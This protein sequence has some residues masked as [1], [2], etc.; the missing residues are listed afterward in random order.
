[1]QKDTAKL[2]SSANLS[3]LFANIIKALILQ[4]YWLFSTK[5]PTKLLRNQKKKKKCRKY[6]KL[7]IDKKASLICYNIT[8]HG[9]I[10]KRPHFSTD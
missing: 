4:M 6:I 10:L 1:M 3:N 9:R 5:K 2:T 8:F 7:K